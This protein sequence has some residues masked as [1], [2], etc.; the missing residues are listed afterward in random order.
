M[1]L[2]LIFL[3]ILLLPKAA[4]ATGGSFAAASAVANSMRAEE[5]QKQEQE[6]TCIEYQDYDVTECKSTR[7]QNALSGGLL[8]AA[9]GYL[10]GGGRGALLGG[11][12]GGAIGVASGQKT[13]TT[14]HEKECVKWKTKTEEKK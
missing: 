10:F 1:K 8:G 9:G 3:T 12:G 7:A 5:A 6:K 11:L 14:H 13:C 2:L 4:F